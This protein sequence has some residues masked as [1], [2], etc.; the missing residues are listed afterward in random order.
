MVALGSTLIGLAIVFAAAFLVLRSL[1]A[2]DSEDARSQ[3]PATVERQVYETLYPRRST[4]VSPARPAA[5]VDA[6]TGEDRVRSGERRGRIGP[7][8]LLTGTQ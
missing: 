1:R 8:G 4:T 6:P 5:P 2:A 7:D 3:D